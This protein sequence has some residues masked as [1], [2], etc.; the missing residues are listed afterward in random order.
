MNLCAFIIPRPIG[1]FIRIEG[2]M[3][4]RFRLF[5][6]LLCSLLIFTS[7]ALA[8]TASIS[9]SASEMTATANAS[10]T[11]AA[12]CLSI[13]WGDSEAHE[14]AEPS[15]SS[16]SATFSHTFSACG[17]HKVA[18]NVKFTN[19]HFA[20]SETDLTIACQM[21]E[22]V[23]HQSNRGRSVLQD[24][25]PA[26]DNPP[27]QNDPPVQV[28]PQAQDDSRA[29]AVRQPQDD[30]RARANRLAQGDSRLPARLE[31]V[32]KGQWLGVREIS[33]AAIGNA[34][35]RDNA[36]SVVD[37]WSPV[38]VNAE[39]CIEGAGSILLLDAA[40]SPRREVWLNTY[41]RD[42]GKTCAQLDRAGTV[43]LMPCTMAPTTVTTAT[44]TGTTAPSPAPTR[45]PYLIADSIDSARSLEECRV[46]SRLTLRFRASPAGSIISLFA[47]GSETSASARTENWFKI[48]HR[49]REGWISAHYVDTSGDCD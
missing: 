43:A 22:S 38:G 45:D 17:T 25:P 15:E 5:L 9:A 1:S 35:V 42:D 3:F 31:V 27:V 39:V 18:L 8:Q 41:Q 26:P 48:E 19:G 28:D 6:P 44:T 20:Y 12:T 4:R 36:M 34:K 37:V 11:A 29:R 33:G 24:D 21:Q 32:N 23:G 10:F 2:A 46:T 14:S 47:G 13:T 16:R 30:S 49:G 7:P 40:Y